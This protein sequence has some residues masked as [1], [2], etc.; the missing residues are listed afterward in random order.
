MTF[1]LK[2]EVDIKNMSDVV[3]KQLKIKLNNNEVNLDKL[4]QEVKYFHFYV[5]IHKFQSG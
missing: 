4:L 3:K 5:P 2:T 1:P